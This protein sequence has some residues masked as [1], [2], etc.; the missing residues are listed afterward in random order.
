M[1]NYTFK[2]KHKTTGAIISVYAVDDYFGHHV[3]GYAIES[4]GDK[5]IYF[6]ADELAELYERM[7]E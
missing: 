1:S 6:T 3:Y 7:E 4:R 2:A 5:P